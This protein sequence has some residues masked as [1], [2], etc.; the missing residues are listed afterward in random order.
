VS[1]WIRRE[2]RLAI[3]LRDGGKCVYC[4]TGPGVTR[5]LVCGRLLPQP[6]RGENAPVRLTPSLSLDHVRTRHADGGNESGNLVAACRRCNSTRR[7]ESIAVLARRVGADADELERA[8]YLAVRRRTRRH[9]ERSAFVWG[10]L[11]AFLSVMGDRD[12]LRLGEMLDH[13]QGA[14]LTLPPVALDDDGW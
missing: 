13:L 6:S 11:D 1:S 7:G 12:V 5:L 9:M 14:G 3:Y 4:G 10:C 2:R 8:A